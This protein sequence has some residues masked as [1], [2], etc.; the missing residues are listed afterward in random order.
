MQTARFHSLDALRGIAA[1]AVML[2]HAGREAPLFMAR[3]YLAADLFFI[4]SG[5]VLAHSYEARL[6]SGMS[7]GAFVRARL[8]RIYP[9]YWLGALTGCLLFAGSPLMILMIP[10]EPGPGLLFR[11]NAPLWSLLFELIAN[12]AWAIMAV[13]CSLR[14]LIGLTLLLG[15]LL[16]PAVVSHGNADIGAF[17]PGALPGLVRTFFSF[18]LG[19]I[20][21]RLF[22]RSGSVRR[23]TPLGWLLLPALAVLLA[24][25]VAWQAVADLVTLGLVLPLIVWLGARWEVG[26]RWLAERLGGLSF[27]L[28]CLHAPF[29]AMGHASPELMAA[30]CAAMIALSLLLDRYYDRPIQ[31]WLKARAQT[32]CLASQA[33]A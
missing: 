29:I 4:L 21:F 12:L 32:P 2:F 14:G 9:L 17:W 19:V 22:V 33:L 24:P 7:L 25:L 8:T 13:R 5:F 26:T 15:A 3:G 28:Y 20:L 16:V 30:I 1:I 27:P 10:T 31:A 11:A 23:A 18:A 6:R